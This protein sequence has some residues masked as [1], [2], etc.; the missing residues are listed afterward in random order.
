MSQLIRTVQVAAATVLMK[1]TRENPSVRSWTNVKRVHMCCA[2]A[3]YNPLWTFFTSY[4][5]LI[6]KI[7]VKSYFTMF[8]LCDMPCVIEIAS[9]G[10]HESTEKKKATGITRA[11]M[12]YLKENLEA[13]EQARREGNVVQVFKSYERLALHYMVRNSRIRMN[14]Y[15]ERFIAFGHCFSETPS[16]CLSIKRSLYL[17]DRWIVS[18]RLAH[19]NFLL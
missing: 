11:Q 10:I 6:A 2:M 4:I 12:N 8:D 13:A 5:V 7:K 3:S 17:I 14:A 18:K 15:L 19:G 1:T 16:S 9:T